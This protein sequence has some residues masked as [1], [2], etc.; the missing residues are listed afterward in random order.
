MITCRFPPTKGTIKVLGKDTVT[1]S[2][3]VKKQIGIVPQEL[4][5]H[6]QMNALQNL[7]FYGA[8]YDVSSKQTR[9][10]SE[11]LLKMMGL[12]ERKKDLTKKFSG[13]MKQRLNILLGLVHDPDIVF[14][15]EPTQ[16]LDPQARYNVWGFLSELKA[17]GKTIFL[18]THYMEE[19]D[20]LCD[21]IAIVDNG[22]IIA[23]GTS[24]ELKKQFGGEKTIEI[25]IGFYK[26]ILPEMKSIEGITEAKYDDKLTLVSSKP[27]EAM[28]TI[29]SKLSKK[30]IR[31][32][33]ISD[34]SLEDVFLG[35]TGKSLR[36]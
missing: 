30:G 27:N 7:D 29:V 6:P 15:D 8:L 20:Y 23:M 3:R 12:D 33:K 35:L 4:S 24:A 9:K 11:E 5:I 17:K 32:I 21:R 31:S 16:G 26:D 28:P 18:T 13:G 14:L 34:P 10:R 19:A 25:E 2:Q 1:D 36:D 22:K